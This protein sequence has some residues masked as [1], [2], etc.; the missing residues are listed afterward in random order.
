VQDVEIISK[1][2]DLVKDILGN[3]P[4]LEKQENLILRQSLKEYLANQVEF[5]GIA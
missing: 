4:K 2:R 3:D 1:A 5:Y